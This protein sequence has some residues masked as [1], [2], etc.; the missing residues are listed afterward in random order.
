MIIKLMR[1][2]FSTKNIGILGSYSIL[3]ELSAGLL[4][5][6][7]MTV[8]QG[9]PLEAVISVND[10]YDL[11]PDSVVITM[12]GTAV[13][14]GITTT[15][16]N[17]SINIPIVT[18]EISIIALAVKQNIYS[19]PE[20]WLRQNIS[21]SGGIVTENIGQSNVMPKEK[22]V[23]TVSITANTMP[24]QLA[25]VTYNENG[26]FLAR[27]SWIKFGVGETVTF[28]DANPFSVSIATQA[29]ATNYTVEEMVKSMTVDGI[30]ENE[31]KTFYSDDE[32][33][34]VRQNMGP[35]GSVI[36]PDYT[37]YNKSNIMAVT[38]F[39]EPIRITNKCSE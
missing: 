22:F 24:L 3:T 12:K 21:G 27:G 2:N 23:G 1:A 25:W 30:S 15:E 28:S 33:L 13:T 8:M 19:K 35:D 6:G 32:T 31:G 34:W 17:I 10:N 16:E 39:E 4:Y 18:G 11:M 5:S 9:M 7:P 20:M 37:T 36:P 14:S 29:V 26:T 38:L